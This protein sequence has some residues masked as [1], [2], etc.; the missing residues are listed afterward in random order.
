MFKWLLL[1][2]VWVNLRIETV[3]GTQKE[4]QLGIGNFPI[5]GTEHAYVLIFT[6]RSILTI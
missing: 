5:P 1:V 6:K 4:V 2:I 3:L